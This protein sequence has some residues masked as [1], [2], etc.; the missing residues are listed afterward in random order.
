[1]KKNTSVFRYVAAVLFI[2]SIIAFFLPIVPYG[3]ITI[4]P[5]DEAKATA[6]W[7]GDFLG[8]DEDAASA[9]DEVEIGGNYSG[10]ELL[11]GLI[12]NNL[13][14]DI[15]EDL[16]IKDELKDYGITAETKVP[17]K[18]AVIIAI[19][20]IAAI[21][22][23]LFAAVTCFVPALSRALRGKLTAILG[24]LSIVL[25][26]VAFVFLILW[27]GESGGGGGIAEKIAN[28]FKSF[29]LSYSFAI[30]WGAYVAGGVLLLGTVAAFI[31]G[32]SSAA[33]S[34][35]FSAG[36]VTGVKGM[37]S[38]A[39]FPIEDFEELIIGR[40][41]ALSHIVVNVGGEKISRK[42]CSISYDGEEGVYIVTDLSSN[43]TFRNNGTQLAHGT[44]VRLTPGSVIYLAKPE[45]SFR[46]G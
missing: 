37:Y 5:S 30:G 17:V 9:L 27:V 39:S 2:L 1:M 10:F 8:V 40:D 13:K 41:A 18:A 6:D 32:S 26:A 45:N 3:S 25:I 29:A 11:R 22:S 21:A 31:G 15:A 42:H 43:G 38:G 35:A 7:I 33:T 24:A 36:F 23:A 34:A 4:E 12:S 19:L 16:D 14:L 20:F 28:A 44:P 46:L